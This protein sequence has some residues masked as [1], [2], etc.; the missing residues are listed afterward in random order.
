MQ[1]YQD[2]SPDHTSYLSQAIIRRPLAHSHRRIAQSEVEITPGHPPAHR[3]N[4]QSPQNAHPKPNK[5][6]NPLAL[7]A[8]KRPIFSWVHCDDQILRKNPVEWVGFRLETNHLRAIQKH[9]D[10]S[11]TLHRT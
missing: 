2:G 10:Q 4:S 8:A 6:R 7:S 9:R 11:Y 5:I 1:P 3:P